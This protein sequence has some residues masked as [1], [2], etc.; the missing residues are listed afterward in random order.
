MVDEKDIWKAAGKRLAE[1]RVRAGY[2]S[3]KQFA[4]ACGKP[5]PTLAKYEQGAREIPMA[6][7]VWLSDT[8]RIDVGWI[9]TG[10]GD[11]VRSDASDLTVAEASLLWIFRRLPKERQEIVQEH[12]EFNLAVSKPAP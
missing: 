12:A 11:A 10:I 5:E 2:A 4:E 8:H 7:L 3:R 1:A 6:L 9:V